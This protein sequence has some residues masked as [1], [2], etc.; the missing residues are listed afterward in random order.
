[1]LEAAEL[2]KSVPIFAELDEHS[3]DELG[4]KCRR[5]SY[6]RNAV[7]MT[8]GE[9]GETLFIIVSGSAK[10]YVGDDNGDEMVLYIKGPGDYIGDIA[11]LDDAPRSASVA[12]LEK[13]VVYGISKSDFLAVLRDNLDI[14]MAI[15]RSLTRRL[16]HETDSVRSLALESVYRRLAKKLDELSV[17]TDDGAS[18]LPRRFSHQE[19]SS[20]IGSSRE[21]VTKVLAE[22]TKGEYIEMRDNCIAICRKLPRDW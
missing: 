16:R 5:T 10:I 18:I 21:M 6:K 14:S 15:I 9:P 7:L 22:L 3:L 13:T 20:M 2:L 8:E 19:L 12:T 11:L 1:M 17:P 4:S